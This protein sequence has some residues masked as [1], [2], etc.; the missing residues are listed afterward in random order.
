MANNSV[1]ASFERLW[2]HILLKLE[3]F[4]S[5]DKL[6]TSYITHSSHNLSE[7]LQANVM[8]IDYDT[9][10]AFDTSEIVIGNISNTS[11]ILGQAILGQMRLG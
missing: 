5:L 3:N 7:L 2:H 10:L 8:D 9:T 1:Y 11:P 4:A 6:N